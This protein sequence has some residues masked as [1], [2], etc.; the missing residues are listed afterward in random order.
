[1]VAVTSVSRSSSTF[2][3]QAA[4]TPFQNPVTRWLLILMLFYFYFSTNECLAEDWTLDV[5]FREIVRGNYLQQA[6][7]YWNLTSSYFN[8]TLFLNEVS[9]C[10][11]SSQPFKCF[12]GVYN[13][14]YR[15]LGTLW[16]PPNAPR[17]TLFGHPR[18]KLDCKYR[19]HTISGNDQRNHHSLRITTSN[20]TNLHE[21]NSEGGSGF[22]IFSESDDGYLSWCPVFDHFDGTYTVTCAGGGKC[23]KITAYVNYE[24][25][26]GLSET[27]SLRP[28]LHYL[29]PP[30]TTLCSSEESANQA[31]KIGN[32]SSM[33]DSRISSEM[34]K[35]VKQVVHF[36][37]GVWRCNLSTVGGL[38]GDSKH[39]YEWFWDGQSQRVK[40][41]NL[42]SYLKGERLM[43]HTIGASHMRESYSFL[44][45]SY[46]E[47]S[48]S[49]VSNFYGG[50]DW[51]IHSAFVAMAVHQYNYLHSICAT[52]D[53]ASE[54]SQKRIIVLHTGDW[55]LFGYSARVLIVDP[56]VGKKLVDV[57]IDI[58]FRNMKCGNLQ[59]F[60]FVTP[61]PYP[62]C[63]RHNQT[64]CEQKRVFRT[65][66]AIAAIRDFYLISLHSAISMRLHDRNNRI[67]ANKASLPVPIHIV[68]AY[69]IA[70]SRLL[71]PEESY[72]LSH[73]LCRC[74]SGYELY[75][76]PAG[77]EIV[78]G[79]VLAISNGSL[80]GE[81]VDKY[82]VYPQDRMAKHHCFH[83]VE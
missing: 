49:K 64:R 27:A 60:V 50:S 14:G 57:I 48:T 29:V 76:T 43:V 17:K 28:A 16:K 56:E 34:A 62:M 47:N 10:Q 82:K 36:H 7:K 33:P 79:I 2:N 59:K 81:T 80:M 20:C 42:S 74:N 18:N 61:M 37:R 71:F 65:N 25:F 72:S 15:M 55:D 6:K 52:F 22:E 51:G 38:G 69:D 46:I 1:M 66:E 4:I 39:L 67:F 23:L 13:S 75:E 77:V 24:H 31:K 58:V 45:N 11:R 32:L 83:C 35:T 54:K 3:F 70:R 40:F 73:F 63:R 30:L 12:A 5:S 53:S 8:N 44:I 68:D 78:N 21:S 9:T 19:I 26:M 41:L